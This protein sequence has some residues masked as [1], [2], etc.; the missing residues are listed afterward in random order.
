MTPDE[1][2]KADALVACADKSNQLFAAQTAELESKV[3]EDAEPNLRVGSDGHFVLEIP[4]AGPARM[5]SFALTCAGNVNRRI[6]EMI[7]FDG[8]TKRPAAGETWSY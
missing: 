3:D 7:D 5:T 2:A 4:G 1:Q 6:I 8:N